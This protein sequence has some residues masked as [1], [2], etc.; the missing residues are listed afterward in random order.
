MDEIDESQTPGILE[1]IRVER[2]RQRG[3]HG[4]TPDHDDGHPLHAWG[5]LLAR[6]AV[7]LSHPAPE[8]A[9][10]DAR[11]TLIEIAAIATAAVESWDRQIGRPE[12][13]TQTYPLPLAVLNRVHGYT[14]SQFGLGGHHGAVIVPPVAP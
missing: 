5:W 11:R 12:P 9:G 7:D 2:D 8:N 4:W 6:R 1:E 3:T 10:I 13:V 14:P